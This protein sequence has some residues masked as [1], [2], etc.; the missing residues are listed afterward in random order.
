LFI[1]FF[2]LRSFYDL[3]IAIVSE[4]IVGTTGGILLFY[5]LGVF[6]R[7]I[8]VELLSPNQ[9][10]S[11][12]EMNFTY[13][14]G[15]TLLLVSY[16]S[17]FSDSTVEIARSFIKADGSYQRKGSL[18]LIA[19]TLYS[20]MFLSTKPQHVTSKC[21]YLLLFVTNTSI[22]LFYSQFIRSNSG[23][24]SIFLIFL[25]IIY[26]RI[27]ATTSKQK[28]RYLKASLFLTPI[29][30]SIFLYFNPLTMSD[31]NFYL[32]HMRIFGYGTFDL[33]S[34]T[35]RI[36]LLSYL[37]DQMQYGLIFGDLQSDV[38]AGHPGEY[39]HNFLLHSLSHLG[40]FGFLL[41]LIIF[42]SLLKKNGLFSTLSPSIKHPTSNWGENRHFVVTLPIILIALL[43]QSIA[44]APFW[45]VVGMYLPIL[46][47]RR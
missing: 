32:S 44:W 16:F 25:A 26:L 14:L 13:L 42:F 12:P 17:Y 1:F 35:S 39:P 45:F 37:F 28:A 29:T 6:S 15:S 7:F 22:L 38:K 20:Y 41:I 10:H 9:N 40:V 4:L 23:F 18:L 24:V 11:F 21:F 8:F 19:Y 46:R 5:I 33:S 3:E 2:V 30:I 27:S 31:F 47:I 43:F 34:V 36:D